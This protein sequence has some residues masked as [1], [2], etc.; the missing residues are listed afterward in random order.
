MNLGGD[1]NV[2]FLTEYIFVGIADI[3]GSFQ[4]KDS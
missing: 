3:S 4:S 2:Q 1:T